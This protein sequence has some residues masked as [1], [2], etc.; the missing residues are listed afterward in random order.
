MA[1]NR[2]GTVS[3]WNVKDRANPVRLSTF[4]DA[5]P[6]PGSM[7]VSPDGESVAIVQDGAVHLYDV[8]DP[9]KPARLAVLPKER[10]FQAAKFS[11]DGRTLVTGNQTAPDGYASL[12]DL[13]DRAQPVELGKLT[14]PG[15]YPASSL[16]FTPDSRHLVTGRG[17]AVVWDIADR[18]NPVVRSTIDLY[19][20]VYT[21]AMSPT[22]PTVAVAGAGGYVYFYD[23][24]RPADPR[25]ITSVLGFDTEAYMLSF[26][27]NGRFLAGASSQRAVVWDVSSSPVALTDITIRNN[28]RSVALSKDGR[29]LVTTDQY[30][31]AALWN[32][33]GYATPVPTLQETAN[34]G[35]MLA[36]HRSAD[37]RS[38]TTVGG[39]GKAVIWDLTD[40]TGPVRRTTVTVHTKGQIGSAVVSSDGRTVVAQGLDGT[41]EVTDLTDES[42]LASFDPGKSPLVQAISP[43]GRTLITEGGGERKVWDLT[44]RSHPRHVRTLMSL[45]S[46]TSQVAFSP[47][48][49]TLAVAED[50]LVWLADLKEPTNPTHLSFLDGHVEPVTTIAFSPDS[51]M[52][53]TG[54]LDQTAILWDLSDR[55]RPHRLA[56]LENTVSV[57]ALAFST[58]S[59]T[60]A[61]GSRE[62]QAV[63]WDISQ[64][65]RPIVLNSFRLNKFG[66][67]QWMQFGPDGRSLAVTSEVGRGGGSFAGVWDLSALSDLRADPSKIGCEIAGRGLTAEEWA[68]KIPELSYIPTCR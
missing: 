68:R 36:G 16:E 43:D 56:T 29:T 1:F 37:G 35:R 52:V 64:P 31:K 5:V 54:S 26:S 50:Q 57:S 21:L 38:M 40:R 42:R 20:S 30:S 23:L 27:A 10:N 44:D 15:D 49:R 65:S 58:D 61:V 9:A 32:V 34:E 8:S 6:W 13:T 2:S 25:Q 46:G 17:E 55:K 4:G 59:K 45:S 53:A 33:Q 63:L 62:T 60:I 19:G 39:D 67:A 14:G 7:S 48:G 22:E 51:S 11:P 3:L 18:D 12:W 41:I 24:S 28:I 66:G 47:D